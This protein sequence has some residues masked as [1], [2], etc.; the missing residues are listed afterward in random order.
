IEQ[1]SEAVKASRNRKSQMERDLS[2]T[3]A[4]RVKQDGELAELNQRIQ[5][6]QRRIGTRLRRLYRLAKA[7]DS[8]TLFQ[9]ARFKSFA[10]DTHVMARLQQADADALRQFEALAAQVR[11]KQR[12]LR[13]TLA[14]LESLRQELEQER[15]VLTE[16]EAGLRESLK[17]LRK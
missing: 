11:D 1:L 12:D 10:R 8:A 5:G 3:T 13:D 7:E 9:L 6:S 14:H 16:R 4:E 2:R 17:N 15:K